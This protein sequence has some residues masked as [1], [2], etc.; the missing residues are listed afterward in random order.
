MLLAVPST[1]SLFAQTIAPKKLPFDKICAGGPH[2]TNPGEVFNEYQASF[3][4]SGFDASVT[5]VVELSDPSGSFATTQTPTTALSPLA[6]TPLDTATDKTLTF[7]VPTNLVGSN[8]YKLRIKSSSGVVSSNFTINGTISTKEL[9]AYFKA[10]NESFFINDKNNTASF[11]NGG[12]L[13]LTIY[14]PTPSSPKTSP[15]NY[16]QLKYNWF[17][18]DVLIPGATTGSLNVNVSGVYYAQLD[19]GPCSDV[20]FSSQR[21]TVSGSTG[22]GAPITSTISAKVDEINYVVEGQTLAVTTTTSA[23]TPSYQWF[24]NDIKI[25][26]EI[27]SFLNV[28]AA[29][30]YKL[31]ITQTSGCV[32]SNEFNF[33]V[34]FKFVTD[35]DV[36]NIPNLVTPNGDGVNDSWIIPDIYTIGTNT[37]IMILSSLGEIVFQTEGYDNYNGWPQTP[38]ELNNFNPVYYYIITPTGQSAK[39]GSITLV[40]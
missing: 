12:N 27:Q 35:Y 17:K 31:I 24:V 14:N 30:K 19:Y 13:T 23:T 21:V 1:I 28:T 39:K 34:A 29:G 10:Y 5:F 15:A 36:S 22:T 4:V 18:D 25:D 40:K 6:G 11:C 38:V 20:N 26:S 2:P 9:P 8:T 32:S 37:Q 3:S 16:P 33:E 7:A